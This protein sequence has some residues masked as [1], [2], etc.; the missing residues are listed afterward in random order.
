MA[1]LN[2]LNLHLHTCIVVKFTK[3]NL[4]QHRSIII[5]SLRSELSVRWTYIK[6]FLIFFVLMQ[7]KYTFLMRKMMQEQHSMHP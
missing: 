7:R 3:Q 2:V 5:D 6:L 1:S 4:V